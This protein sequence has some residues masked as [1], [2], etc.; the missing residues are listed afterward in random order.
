MLTHWSQF[1]TYVNPTSEDIKLHII[2]IIR[3]TLVSC[4]FGVGEK[5]VWFV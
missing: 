3:W 1:D 2:I 4:S 5:L